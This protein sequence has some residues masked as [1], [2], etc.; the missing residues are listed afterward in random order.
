MA[1]IGDLDAQDGLP[2]AIWFVPRAEGVQPSLS[3]E[4][5]GGPKRYLRVWLD[6]DDNDWG[7]SLHTSA[8]RLF[9]DS[10]RPP[11]WGTKPDAV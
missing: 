6:A 2:V 1:D 9:G 10:P 5:V 11:A 8:V 4:M 3:I 7:W